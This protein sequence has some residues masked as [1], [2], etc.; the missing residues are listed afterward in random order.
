MNLSSEYDQFRVKLSWIQYACTGGTVYE[1]PLAAPA[2]VNIGTL[3]ENPWIHNLIRDPQSFWTLRLSCPSNNERPERLIAEAL[4]EFEPATI[5]LCN[6]YAACGIV[7]RGYPDKSSGILYIGPRPDRGSII[8][9]LSVQGFEDADRTAGFLEMLWGYRGLRFPD[10]GAVDDAEIDSRVIRE[11][12]AAR[13]FGIELPDEWNPCLKLF[14]ESNGDWLLLN[15]HEEVGWWQL[16]TT[17]IVPFC[18]TI[19]ELALAFSR[20][21]AHVND[22]NIK[23][24]NHKWGGGFDSWDSGKYL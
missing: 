18:D 20:L 1:I 16:E 14:R 17:Q 22:Y 3:T 19:D 4:A 5:V 13:Y 10:G 21:L 8:R 6:D 7:P 15:R 24:P 9:N 2:L 11:G 12:L 23:N